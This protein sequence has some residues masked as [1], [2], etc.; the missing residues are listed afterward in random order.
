MKEFNIKDIELVDNG[1]KSAPELLT[2]EFLTAVNRSSGITPN[3]EV[4]GGEYVKFPNKETQRVAG[5]DH[6]EGGVPVKLPDT[7]KILSK[8]LFLSKQQVETLS[9]LFDVD[10]TTKDSYATVLDK[11]TKKIGLKKLNEEQEQVFTVLE[12]ENKK[13]NIDSKTKRV[14]NAYLS[15]KINDIEQNKKPLEEQRAKLF[16]VLFQAQEKSKADS[17]DQEAI[18]RY[19]GIQKSNFEAIATKLGLDPMEAAMMIKENRNQKIMFNDGG[20]FRGGNTNLITGENLTPEQRSKLLIYYKKHNPQLADALNQNKVKWE[21]LVFNPGLVQK[22]D[23]TTDPRTI[24]TEKQSPDRSPKLLKS[25]TFGGVDQGMVD[26]FVLADYAVAK[27]KKPITEMT[28]E[29]IG[30]LQRDY[31]TATTALTE[32]SFNYNSNPGKISDD[33]FGNRTASFARQNVTIKGTKPEVI[34]VDKLFSQTPEQI[35][36]ILKDYGL[37][38]KDIEKYQNAAVKFITI[39]PDA[40]EANTVPAVTPPKKEEDPTVK[41]DE[42]TGIID[43]VAQT[44]GKEYPRLFFSP[45]QSVLPPQAPEAHLKANIRTGRIDPIR[46]GI[47]QTIQETANQRNFIADQVSSLP[48]SQRAAVLANLLASSQETINKASVQANTINAQNQSQAE[49]FN[50]QQAGQEDIANVNNALDYER[51]QF[52]AKAKSDESIRQYYDYNRKINITNLQNNQK[53]NL[54][55]SLFP[56]YDLD[57]FGASTNYNPKSEWA[58]VVNNRPQQTTTPKTKEEMEM[59]NAE[60]KARQE[61]ARLRGIELRNQRLMFGQGMIGGAGAPN[62]FWE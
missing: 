16:D 12:K 13:E 40:P 21:S 50:I 47:E 29:E 37:S 41:L 30:V 54:L 62:L 3:A 61:E 4:E 44:P 32:G 34:D 31:N 25:G 33:K 36:V 53:L 55:D 1:G 2:G 42:G 56:D 11:Y 8:S 7:T 9:K 49:L 6:E 10:L 58:P 60:M 5:K 22:I 15:K 26:G 46:V 18:F 14:N 19:G 57:F 35:D 17:G 27:Y 43:V 59:Y 39:N 38:H 45:D 52:T 24:P 23:A 28:P 51:R 48:E 20:I